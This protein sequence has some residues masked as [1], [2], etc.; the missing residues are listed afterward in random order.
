MKLIA[1]FKSLLSFLYQ[2]IVLILYYLKVVLKKFW[3]V[4][5]IILSVLISIIT[6][7]AFRK[8]GGKVESDD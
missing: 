8:K 2:G 7:K 5:V 1:F 4:I 6:L 3:K